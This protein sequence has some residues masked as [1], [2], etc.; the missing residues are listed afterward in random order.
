MKIEH[1]S[2]SNWENAFRGMRNP[3][4]SWSKSDSKFGLGYIGAQREKMSKEYPH[5]TFNDWCIKQDGELCEYAAIG[6][7]DIK[8]AKSLIKGGPVHSKFLRQ[9]FISMDITAPLFV[10][11]ELDTYKVGTAANS[12][13]TM[14]TIQKHPIDLGCFEIGD[15]NKEIAG[16]EFIE[17]S[18]IPY[19]EHLRTKYNDLNKL[20]WDTENPEIADG[21]RKEAM[22]YW[23]ELIRW[24]PES[25]L[26]TRT[27]TANYE[28]ARNILR[29]RDPHKLT[30][31]EPICQALK[32]L[33]Y[34]KDFLSFDD[35]STN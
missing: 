26:Q 20:S 3:Y 13:S 27:W 33:P 24:L 10:W 18:L 17:S 31:W 14:H 32:D 9:I 28:I 8:L 6:K 12:C 7:E 25:W 22:K 1:I 15:F 11:K 16:G 29:W 34:G 5:L 23:K 2:T 30:E 35:K 19:L 21:Y 4:D